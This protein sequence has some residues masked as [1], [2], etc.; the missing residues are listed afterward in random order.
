MRVCIAYITTRFNLA[1]LQHINSRLLC[2]GTH[3]LLAWSRNIV[4]YLGQIKSPD[5]IDDY[6][7]TLL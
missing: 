5:D 1:L 3:T 4:Y 2:F 6:V 7:L